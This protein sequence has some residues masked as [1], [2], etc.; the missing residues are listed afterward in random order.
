[1]THSLHLDGGETRARVKIPRR[2]IGGSQALHDLSH[3][4]GAS[5]SMRLRHDKGIPLNLGGGR[6]VPG[7]HCTTC[8]AKETHAPQRTADLFDHLAGAGN[9]C[10]WHFEAA[11]Y[12]D[13][14][15]KPHLMLRAKKAFISADIE[16][17]RHS[18]PDPARRISVVDK[19]LHRTCSRAFSV[20]IE[21][22]RR[23]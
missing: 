1:M 11:C 15:V 12:R 17:N 13:S 19:A 20:P 16:M 7:R 3:S 21:S 2:I 18:Y 4:L 10:R 22:E 8:Q 14:D 5:M 23:L 6:V 9:Q